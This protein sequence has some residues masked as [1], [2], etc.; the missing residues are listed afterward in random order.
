LCDCCGIRASSLNAIIART[1]RENELLQEL[2]TRLTADV[3][4][5]KV[6][7]RHAAASLPDV[8]A[9]KAEIAAEESR[10]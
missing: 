6:D 8:P 9:T 7:V 4:T 3:V 1:R 2:H 10:T 5:G